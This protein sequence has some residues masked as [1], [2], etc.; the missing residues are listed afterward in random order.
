VVAGQQSPVVGA[1]EVEVQVHLSQHL[2]A[3]CLVGVAAAHAITPLRAPGVELSAPLLTASYLLAGRQVF[4]HRSI[5]WGA[6]ETPVG[7]VALQQA[8]QVAPAAVQP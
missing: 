2:T 7:S 1:F 6:G 4:A 5:G 8:A 3:I